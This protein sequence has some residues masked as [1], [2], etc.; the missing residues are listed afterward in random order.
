MRLERR[1]AG[2]FAEQQV[3]PAEEC[4]MDVDDVCSSLLNPPVNETLS[5]RVGGF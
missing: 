4:G 5:I 1:D 3:L 2:A